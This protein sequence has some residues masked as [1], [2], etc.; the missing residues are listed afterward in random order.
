M[1]LI[2]FGEA[3]KEKPG[4]IVNNIRYDV[5]GFIKDF[6]EDFFTS[7]GLVQ[8][9]NYE[10]RSSIDLPVI[11]EDVRLGSPIAKPSKLIC[12]GLNYV[13]HA[14]ESNMA[15]PKEPV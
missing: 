15:T 8:L 14:A 2:R 11:D 13:D 9:K 4:I 12:I 10:N 1:K 3:G 6:D 5:S 7:D